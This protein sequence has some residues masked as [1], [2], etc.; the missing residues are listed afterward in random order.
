M[1][2]KSLYTNTTGH[3]N[4][5]F[6]T[7]A[8]FFNSTGEYNV[9]VGNHTLKSNTIGYNNTALGADV[10]YNNTSG[11]KNTG[12][13]YNALGQNTSGTFNVAIGGETLNDNVTGTFNTAVGFAALQ[14]NL[15]SYNTAAGGT[16][17]GFNTTGS[18]NAGYGVG[19]LSNNTTGS[20]NTGDGA[21]SLSSITTGSNNTALGYAA[22]VSTSALS[23]TTVIGATATVNAS[24]KVRIGDV[25][26]TVIEG[27]VDWTFTSDGRFKSNL[28]ESDVKGLEF[29]K[30]LRPVVYNF[31]TRRFQEFL[32]KN[33]SDSI[34]Q[35]YL[36]KD[37][38]ASTSI[39]RSGFI[40]QEVEKAADAI[41]Y[42]FDAVHK[43]VDEND[44]YGLSYGQFVVPLV[45]AVQELSM[46]NNKMKAEV[47]RLRIQLDDLYKKIATTEISSR[48]VTK[49]STPQSSDAK[50]MANL[51]QNAPNP[52]TN[53]TVIRFSI[54]ESARSAQII[55]TDMKGTTLKATSIGVRGLGS[56]IITAGTLRSGS[57]I[58]SLIVDGNNVDSKQMILTK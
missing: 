30:L 39:R 26:V 47:E 14:D 48:Q 54:P 28:S 2:Y 23:N 35:K 5:G 7:E 32:T 8:L 50:D 58:Y 53:N 11:F 55:V 33:M 56:I 12:V 3:Q 9:A 49:L 43:P 25:N 13:G 52:F 45:K 15:S 17:L 46:D 40:A 21:Y 51:E 41:G 6:G 24:N 4:L 1:G 19:A 29:I 22:N 10:L 42:Q 37:F 57:Y 38:T 44:N 27:Q 16:A 34:R 36:D 20:Y 18:Y 31:D